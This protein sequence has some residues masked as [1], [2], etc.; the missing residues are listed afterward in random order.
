MKLNSSFRKL[1]EL[2]EIRRLLSC[3]DYT[4]VATCCSELLQVYPNEADAFYLRAL[5][6]FGLDETGEAISDVTRAIELFPGEPAFY[7]FRGLWRTTANLLT[8]AADDFR[9]V[10][11]LE[12][13]LDSVYYI[14]SARM[15]LAVTCYLSG[16]LP[17]TR[18]I[19]E[20]V[21]EDVEIFV[22]NR[23]WTLADLLG[24][25]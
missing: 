15:G 4:A 8:E 5:A 10:M 21:P 18:R 16:D 22:A 20:A 13:E 2:R 17:Q 11:R 9:A 24:G 1:R 3:K 12:E 23:H 19:L 14:N 25:E 7:Y 6:R